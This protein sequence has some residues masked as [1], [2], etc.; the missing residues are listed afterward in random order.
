MFTRLLLPTALCGVMFASLGAQAPTVRI[1]EAWVRP[2]APS[3][4]VTGGY[5]T[6]VKDGGQAVSLVAGTSPRAKSVELHE[7]V[8]DGEVMRMRPIQEIVIPARGR[9]T[10]RPVACT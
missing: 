9:T 1:E 3:R 4:D 10:P 8:M 2:P 5:L 6:I 7:M